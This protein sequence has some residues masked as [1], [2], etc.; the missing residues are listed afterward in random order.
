ML[1]IALKRLWSRP[2]LTLLSIFGVVVAVGLVISIPI[3]AEATSFVVLREELRTVSAQSGRPLFSMRVYVLPGARYPLTLDR[4]KELAKLIEDTLVTQVGLPV[5]SLSRHIETTTLILQTREQASPYSHPN[6]VLTETTLAVL[7]GVGPHISVLEGE[8]META[9]PVPGE[10]AVW[11]HQAVADEVGV[12]AGEQ[13]EV[14]DLRRSLSI[15]VR[16]AGIWRPTDPR[17]G[18]WFQD[19]DQALSSVLLVREQDY[20]AIAEPLLS[21]RI[22]FASW[23][24]VMDDSLLSPSRMQDYVVGMQ[25][26]AKAISRSL[27]DTQI[28][29]S[30]LD[31]LEDSIHRKAGLTALMFVFSVPLMGFVLYFLALISRI[32]IRW[33]RRETAVLVSRGICSRQLLIVGLI[34]SAI[35]VGIGGPLGILTGVQLAR[36]MSYTKSFLSFVWREPLPISPTSLNVPLLFVTMVTALIARLGPISRSARTSVVE[37]ERA[38]ARPPGKPFWQ[39]LYLDFALLAVAM[40]ARNRLL[41]EGT[42][43]PQVTSAQAAAGPEAA[44]W[45]AKLVSQ[46]HPDVFKEQDPLLFLVPA[47]LTLALSLLLVRLFPLLMGIGDRLSSLGSKATLYLAFRQLARQSGQYT[48][49]LLLVI[50][51]LSLGAFMASMAASLDRWLVDRVYYGIGADVLLKQMPPVSD[52]PFAPPPPPTEGAWILPAESY[53]D[54]PGVRGAARVCFYPAVIDVDGQRG[55]PGTFI[56]ID[57]LDLPEVLFFRADFAGA[58]LGEMMNRLAQQEDGV[59]ISDRA[60]AYGHYE[61]GDKVQI[62]VNLVDVASLQADYTIVGTYSYFPTVYE[63]RDDTTAVI[64]NL[65]HLYDQVGATLLHDVWLRIDPASD[66]AAMRLDVER[67]GVYINFWVDARD[68]IAREQAR[69]ERIGVFATLTFGFLGAAVLSGIGLLVY[70]YASLQERLFRFT[71]LR[72]VGLSLRQLVSQVSIE[73]L[74]LMI[75]GV[76]GGAGIGVL[77]SDWFIPFFQAADENVLEPPTLLP[78]VAWGGIGRISA[79]FALALVAA[80]VVVISAALRGGVFQALRMGDRE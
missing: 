1:S 70:N 2:L 68:A 6:T 55:L 21:T 5:L 11:M 24:L 8:P 10:L 52:D 48:S 31:A 26:G 78:I 46:F 13:Y 61:I 56:G 18:Y 12:Q 79:V 34:E 17:D 28:D 42:L 77:A 62:R 14:R 63:E 45:L 40:Y 71:I 53:V 30:P 65:D 7:S 19:P 44:S 22:G 38:R 51:S 23:F 4:T 50:T 69:S 57:R 36:L 15:P 76:V 33:Q 35:L 32:T 9:S 49:A 16:I 25:R 47:L 3:L 72:A 54:L 66:Q 20:Q 73:Y 27:P 80:Q 60:L 43:V 74:V 37:H 59:I 39:R 58:S 41:G 29:G 75:Y 64:G 67:M